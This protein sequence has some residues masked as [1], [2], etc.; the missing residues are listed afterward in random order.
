M[1]ANIRYLKDAISPKKQSLQAET[2]NEYHKTQEVGYI[3]KNDEALEYDREFQASYHMDMKKTLLPAC[4]LLI[5]PFT[6]FGIFVLIGLFIRAKFTKYSVAE[7]SVEYKFDF[8]VNRFSSFNIEK[9]TGVTFRE[10]LLD[11][12]FGTCSVVFMSIGNSKDIVFSN[13]KKEQALKAH[14][15]QKIGVFEQTPYTLIDAQ[16]TLMNFIKAHLRESLGTL[17]FM[18]IFPL[19]SIV[20]YAAISYSNT[21]LEEIYWFVL[22][23]LFIGAI[24]LLILGLIFLYAKFLYSPRF[25]KN[26][27]SSEGVKSQKG[28]II[29]TDSYAL[30]RNIKG[31]TSV[32]YPFTKVGKLIFNIAGEQFI[33]TGKGKGQG[34]LRSYTIGMPYI[35]DIFTLHETID[36]DMLGEE[37]NTQIQK[38]SRQALLNT[39]LLPTIFLG[40]II[41]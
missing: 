19:T 37:L 7:T 18:T 3:D 15:K 6:A 27:I 11:K 10:S 2:P 21:P 35:A 28:I 38:D 22:A 41:L 14:I 26:A 30:S 1:I 17:L 5:P 39:L 12:I 9:I 33:Q 31:L 8:F 34:F 16:F 32:K 13:I 23:P 29:Q 25:Y 24:I 40:A 36:A 4:I 20:A